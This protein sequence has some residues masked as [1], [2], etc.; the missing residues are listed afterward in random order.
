MSTKRQLWTII[1]S[2][3]GMLYRLDR[4]HSKSWD[5]LFCIA[6]YIWRRTVLN[7][8]LGKHLYD[9]PLNMLYP[10]FLFVSHTFALIND[11]PTNQ[12]F[13]V[14]FLQPY[15]SARQQAS[16]K[17]RS[18]CS[19]VASF[20]LERSSSSSSVLWSLPLVI[21]WLRSLWTSS[22]VSLS[23]ARG[24]LHLRQLLCAS[25]ALSSIS[26]K[27]VSVFSQILQL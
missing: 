25:I 11:V 26:R 3:A 2:S 8:G 18:C 6:S 14:M 20:P 17:L 1:N 24:T 7:Y 4:I 23:A 27:L 21:V 9:V 13:R 16:L 12:K 10:N 22:R 19:T 5:V 15:S